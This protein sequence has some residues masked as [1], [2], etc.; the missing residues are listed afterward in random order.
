[1]APQW[2]RDAAKK[3]VRAMR[4]WLGII[5]RGDDEYGEQEG[6]EMEE[7]EEEGERQEEGRDVGVREGAVVS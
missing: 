6:I 3:R 2:K 4:T 7:L 1:M 5:K